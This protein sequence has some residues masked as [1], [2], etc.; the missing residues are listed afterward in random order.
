[1]RICYL[2]ALALACSAL[3]ARGELLLSEAWVRALP[4][5]Q[6]AT[7]AYLTARNTGSRPI[8]IDGASATGAGRAE[9]HVTREVD[10]LL[11]MQRLDEISLAPGEE[12]ALTPGGIHLMLLEL[13]RMPAE[14]DSVTLC[15]RAAGVD[16]ACTEAPV[17]R[18]GPSGHD[19]HGHH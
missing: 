10:G 15:L 7:A 5:T 1:M 9:I 14:G 19:H 4:P 11:R 12:V 17:R 6:T 3:P 16:A 8:R 2:A 13:E 18:G